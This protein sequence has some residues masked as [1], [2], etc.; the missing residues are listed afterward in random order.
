MNKIIDN[1]IK[2]SKLIEIGDQVVKNQWPKGDQDSLRAFYGPRGLNLVHIHT[3]YPLRLSWKLG[4]RVNRIKV[5]KRVAD[6]Q[7]RVMEEI[8][9][10]YGLDAIQALEL[11]IWGGCYSQRKKRDNKHEWSV[12]SWGA[13]NDWNPK[14][15][16]LYTPWEHSQF[17]EPAY[18]PFLNAWIREG[19]N[20]LG[21]DIGR[22]AMHIEAV[23]NDIKLLDYSPIE[24]N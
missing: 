1:L 19:W 14:K 6:S 4:K 17:S 18:M 11:D 2:Q 13:A 9:A 7:L 16:G 24:I 3:P 20:I 22:D 12:H 21:M 23:A 5:H 10:V 8:L 15:N